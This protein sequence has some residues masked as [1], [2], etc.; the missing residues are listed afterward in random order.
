MPHIVA[1]AHWVVE[2]V[3]YSLSVVFWLRLVS[4]RADSPLYS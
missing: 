2:T 1:H 3:R 4:H